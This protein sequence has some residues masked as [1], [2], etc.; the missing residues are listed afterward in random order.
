MP[1]ATAAAHPL[2]PAGFELDQPAHTLRFTRHLGAAPAK[3]FAAWTE[4]EQISQW[5]DPAGERLSRCEIDL[6]VGGEFVFVS[7]GHP[8][9]PFAGQYREIAPPRRLVFM[10]MGAEGRVMLEPSETGTLMTVEIICSG[11][12]HLEQFVKL[13]VAAGTSQ[14]LD[15][16][17]AFVA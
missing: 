11:A 4:P 12:E 15:N 16:L 14:T 3:A 2:S 8:D 17:A 7:P 1:P 13:G 9:M 10:A 5:W 6:R